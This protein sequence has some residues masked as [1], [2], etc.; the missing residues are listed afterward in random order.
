[1]SAGNL[2]DFLSPVRSETESVFFVSA[3]LRLGNTGRCP[4]ALTFRPARNPSAGA[5]PAALY[6]T[7]FIS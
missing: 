7:S 6:W 1:M 2:D 3:S 5:L 4:A